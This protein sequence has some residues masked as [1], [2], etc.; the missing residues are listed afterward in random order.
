MLERLYERLFALRNAQSEAATPAERASIQIEIEEL[1]DL[2]D[3][4]K[5]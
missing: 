3:S 5:G 2:I 4:L 1:L